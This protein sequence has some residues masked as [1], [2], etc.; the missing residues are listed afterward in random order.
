MSLDADLNI[1]VRTM[2]SYGNLTLRGSCQKH[3]A[4]GPISKQGN[5]KSGIIEHRLRQLKKL[6]EE[7]PI[8][9]REFSQKK[10]KFYRSFRVK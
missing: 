10:R 9:E 2:G 7:G 3:S 5:E 6:R 1:K 4:K 8:S